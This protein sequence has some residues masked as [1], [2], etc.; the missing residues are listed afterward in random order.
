VTWWTGAPVTQTIEGSINSL[1]TSHDRVAAASSAGPIAIFTITGEPVATAAGHAGGAQ[2]VAFTADG[3]M[4]ASGGQDRAIRLWSRDGAP[5][6]SAPEPHGDVHLVE[7]AADHV[8]AA[9]NDGA[10]IDYGPRLASARVIAQ[11]TG[12]VT[13]LAA[14]GSTVLSAGRDHVVQPAGVALDSTA[15]VLV[16]AGRDVLAITQTG[17]VER[18]IGHRA[19]VLVDH[20]ARTA[21][22]LP[23]GRWLVARDDGALV[24]VPRDVRPLSELPAAIRTATRLSRARD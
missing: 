16:P 5:V 19:I 12:M 6:A 7:L 24:I 15:S 20:G 9:G 17:A 11:H 22:A 21:L 18:I 10:V 1:A 14:D 23:D 8:I 13:A 2:A 3:A 4:F